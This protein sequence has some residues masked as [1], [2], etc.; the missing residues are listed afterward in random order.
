MAD[1]QNYKYKEATHNPTNMDDT[2]DDFERQLLYAFEQD[3]Q[4][5]I[6]SGYTNKSNRNFDY[7]S[8]PPSV[9]D[10]S[11]LQCHRTPDIAPPEMIE[12][13]G[14]KHGFNWELGQLTTAQTIYIPASNVAMDVRQGI[15]TFMPIFTGIFAVLILSVNRLLQHTVIKPIAHSTRAANQLSV[16]E[17]NFQKNWQLNYLKKL[18]KRRDEAGKLTRDFLLMAEKIFYRERD[19]HRAVNDSTKEL[20]AEIKERTAIERKLGRQV[21]KGLLQER[22]TQ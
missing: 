22:I 5:N 19:L 4:T 6:L 9:K 18:T 15:F 8:R 14:D 16:S 3:R 13:Y 1:F 10:S 21:K 11:C 17:S 2:P 7:I 20:R 12:V